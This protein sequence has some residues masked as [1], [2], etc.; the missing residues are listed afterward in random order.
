MPAP[1]DSFKQFN[2]SLRPSKQ[3]E[4][5]IIIEVLLRLSKAG[6]N[7][8]EYTY[9]GF[10]SVY[11]VDFVMFHKYLFIDKMVCVEWGDIERRMKFNKPYKFIKLK[12]CPLS[13]YIPKIHLK[14]RLFA[15]LD[16]DRSLDPEMLLD[17]DGMITRL[18]PGSILAIT[19]DARPKLAKDLL[20]DADNL[21]QIERELVTLKYY[22]EWFEG[23]L[24]EELTHATISQ[25]NV[26]PLFYAAAVQRIKESVAKRRPGLRFVQLFNYL[27]Q[28]GAPM[29]TIGGVLCSEESERLLNQT[30]VLDHQFVRTDQKQME[31]SVPPLTIIEKRWL[32]MRMD[33]HLTTSK[34]GFELD[35]KLLENY[36]KFY[37]EYPTYLE[38]LL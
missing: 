17:V 22:R 29:L 24:E 10:G 15:W 5:K 21:S 12:L 20:N 3:V 37:K 32:D 16:Y 19:I 6:F 1:T 30:G 8:T 7:I 11:Y 23:Y 33:P 34:L 25:P 4:R 13:E 31:I 9:I 18:A 35:E 28:D 27:Y 36:R 2:Y 14:E 38:A 26:A